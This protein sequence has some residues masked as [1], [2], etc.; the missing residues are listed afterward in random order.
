MLSG[1][2]VPS[3]LVVVPLL[4]PHAL[5]DA[6]IRETRLEPSM[7]AGNHLGA[8]SVSSWPHLPTD[9]IM[10]SCFLLLLLLALGT[11]GIFAVAYHV[12]GRPGSA[13]LA[14]CGLGELG[15]LQAG[16]SFRYFPLVLSPLSNPGATA[17][18][19]GPGCGVRVVS[20][21]WWAKA[22]RLWV[23]PC[24]TKSC[25]GCA[26]QARVGLGSLTV[27]VLRDCWRR[28]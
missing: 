14:G 17:R 6:Y 1:T 19:S 25:S 9:H 22:L 16:T 18:A 13:G 15:V 23:Q 11:C 3:A 27:I 7:L 8:W 5:I 21:G 2:I 20:S 4:L 24:W 28:L 12:L 10:R 26:A